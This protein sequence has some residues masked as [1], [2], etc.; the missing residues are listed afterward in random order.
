MYSIMDSKENISN[1]SSGS[2]FVAFASAG[3]HRRAVIRPFICLSVRLFVHL[4]IRQQFTVG[5]L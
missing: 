3:G 2:L 5:V 4:S 1:N